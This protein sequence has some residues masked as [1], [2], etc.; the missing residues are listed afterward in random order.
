M[1]VVNT[2]F[3]CNQNSGVFNYTVPAVGRNS[4]ANVPAST[5]F[6]GANGVADGKL[7]TFGGF[8]GGV[9]TAICRD[10]DPV[11]DAWALNTSL[12]GGA[13]QLA[14]IAFDGTYFYRVGGL[15]TVSLLRHDRYD[16]VANTWT[17]GLS[18]SGM[19]AQRGG[20]LVYA[21]NGL[22]YIA[23][24][25]GDL[26]GMYSYDP[27]NDAG[28]WTQL[29]NLPRNRLAPTAEVIGSRIYVA[30][31]GGDFID[32]YDIAGDSWSTGAA[33]AAHAENY[34][35]SATA[36]GYFYLM[37]AG[38]GNVAQRYD[39]VANSW[40]N[41]ANPPTAQVQQACAHVGNGLILMAGGSADGDATQGYIDFQGS[42][43]TAPFDGAA[44][45]GDALMNITTG[46]TAVD[47]AF[48][49]GDRLGFR[50][51]AWNT[52]QAQKSTTLVAS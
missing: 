43:I 12:P 50:V 25:S 34:A 9:N 21:P 45:G 31:Y 37:S 18:H 17:T 42:I 6:Y 40:V 35:Q 27:A 46:L 5:L 33:P 28:G 44:S 48:S 8:S 38:G 41:V 10:Y 47:V 30:G 24:G 15:T 22:L 14:S 39:P 20:A 32:I 2:F 49:A 3:A 1:R 36:N 13:A 51:N 7:Y 16:P 23:G 26:N 29:A 19:A 11:A 52:A 4:Y